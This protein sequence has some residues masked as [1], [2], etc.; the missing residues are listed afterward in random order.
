MTDTTPPPLDGGTKPP[1]AGSLWA[2]IGLAWLIV[3]AGHVITVGL[4]S[5]LRSTGAVLVLLPSPEIACVVV[6]ILLLI[7]GR[8]RTGLG[9]F[10][11]LASIA[12]VALLLVAACFGLLGLGNMH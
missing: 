1:H 2:G 4:A 9:I 6:A 3:L 10:L 5:S 11:G 12:A 8:T 7:R